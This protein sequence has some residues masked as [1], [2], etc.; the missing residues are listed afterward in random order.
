LFVFKSFL[1]LQFFFFSLPSR[2]KQY[3]Q[4]GMTFSS[5]SG[6]HNHIAPGGMRLTAQCMGIPEAV[7]R[8][9]R[10]S[11]VQVVQLNVGDG[12]TGG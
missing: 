5:N 10:E 3:V 11:S 1:I 4:T 8:P 2:I 7:Q 12:S 6:L 9:L